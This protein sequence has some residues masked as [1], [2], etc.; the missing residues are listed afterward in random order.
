[1]AG[2]FVS[3]LLIWLCDRFMSWHSE[4]CI[5]AVRR[6]DTHITHTYSHTALCFSM[7]VCE[8]SLHLHVWFSAVCC[9]SKSRAF[10]L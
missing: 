1:M 10:L 5:S 9:M 8:V 4:I 3:R 7:C 6:S 2:V